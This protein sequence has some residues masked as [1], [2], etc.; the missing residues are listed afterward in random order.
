MIDKNNIKNI[1]ELTPMQE[2]MLFHSVYDGANGAY[3]E[4]ARYRISGELDRTCFEGAWNRLVERHDILRTAFVYQKVKEPIQI[5]LKQRKIECRYED[6]SDYP[7]EDRIAFCRDYIARDKKR[8]FDLS[9][10]ALMR[11]ALFRLDG[12]THEVL[13]SFHHIL[14][15]G[16]SVG[17]IQEEFIK[18]YR[19][20]LTGRGPELEQ[21]RPFVNYVRWL[22][23]M[24]AVKAH[25]YWAA[26]LEGYQKP[27]PL[28][29]VAS[30]ASLKEAQGM[31]DAAFHRHAFTFPL[32]LS[33]G[34]K[35]V[36]ASCH[37]TLNT[38]VQTLWGILLCKYHD[39]N[40]VVFAASV[41]GRPPEIKG[42]EKMV[43]LFINAVPVRITL[44][45]N[46]SLGETLSALQSLELTGKS[47]H[48]CS[49]AD[50]QSATPLKQ[51]LINHILVF[52][53]YP[54]SEV[55]KSFQAENNGLFRLTDFEHQDHT[56]YD[57]TVQVFPGMSD[58]APLSFEFIY[59][60]R[61]YSREAIEEIASNLTFL[62][63][64]MT[65]GPS[66]TLNDLSI[67]R[68]KA[69]GAEGRAPGVVISATFTAEPVA[70]YLLWWGERFGTK[71]RVSFAPYHQVFQELLD[72]E[73]T[74]RR[75]DGLRFILLRPEDWGNR[76]GTPDAAAFAD[77]VDREVD[78][79][80]D[81]AGNLGPGTVVGTFPPSPAISQNK[82]LSQRIHWAVGKIEQAVSTMAGCAYVDFS[83][84]Q[85]HYG[86]AGR[87]HD[88]VGYAQGKIP[89]TE[90]YFSAA[91]VS[92]MRTIHRMTRPPF[93]VIVLDCDNTLWKGVCGEDGAHNV[94]VTG[95]FE[96]LQRLMVDKHDQGFLI[97]LCS[98]NNEAD[99][100]EVFDNHGG[101]VL[102][103]AHVVAHRINWEP[104][105]ANI[106][107]LA[108]ELNLSLSSFIFIDDSGVEID[109]VRDALP[110]VF[111]LRLPEN[112]DH[113]EP[114]FRH[115]WAFDKTGV[116]REDKQRTRMYKAEKERNAFRETSSS[117]ASY[118]ANLDLKM[119]VYPV[120]EPLYERVAQLTKRTN[121]FNCSAIPRSASDIRGL[122]SRPD[123]FCRAVSV[124]DRYGEYGITGVVIAFVQG[125]AIVADTFL[126][127][128]RVLGRGVEHALLRVLRD[129]CVEKNIPTLSL[130][131]VETG[132]N[133]PALS[134]V[135]AVG[136]KWAV[137]DNGEGMVER[138]VAEPILGAGHITIR[139]GVYPVPEEPTDTIS[140]LP[141][142]LETDDGPTALDPLPVSFMDEKKLDA[143]IDTS[144]SLAPLYLP[145]YYA[146]AAML[147]RIRPEGD[148]RRES[149]TPFVPPQTD[150]EKILADHVKSVLSVN[151][152]GIDDD[153]FMIGGHSLKATRVVS[154]IYRQFGVEISLKDFFET[155][156]IRHLAL[157]VDQAK[158]IVHMREIAALPVRETYDISFGQ[159]R[160]WALQH[161]EE[162]FFAYNMSAAY[163]VHG[164]LDDV[165]LERALNRVVAR[166]EA[167]RTVFVQDD[168]GVKQRI[169]EAMPC[170]VTRIRF[171]DDAHAEEAVQR[172]AQSAIRDPFDL[173]VGP[174]LKVVVYTLPQRETL[175]LFIMHHIICDGWSFTLFAQDLFTAY[176]HDG[177]GAHDLDSV[178]SI[179]YKEYAAWHNRLMSGDRA[180]QMKQFWQKTLSGDLPC[181]DLKTDRP[182]PEY[183]TSNGMTISRIL[184]DHLV[185]ALDGL[186]EQF[187]VT[188]YMAITALI[189]LL[190]SRYS[191][192]R[193]II[194]GTPVAGR[195]HADFETVIG[196]FVNTLAIRIRVEP[197]DS[198]ETLIERTRNR[199]TGAFD[200][201]D[202][203]F[204]ALVQ[205]LNLAR[206]TSR[207]PLFDVMIVFQN[208]AHGHEK[209]EDIRVEPFELSSGVS[210]YDLVFMVTETRDALEFSVTFNSDLFYKERIDHMVTHVERLL[211]GV[212]ADSKA[213]VATLPML[214]DD[215]REALLTQWGTLSP[216]DVSG[217]TI[218][219]CFEARVHASPDGVALLY[220]G[221]ELT[222]RELDRGADRVLALLDQAGL[223]G[224]EAIAGVMARRG[225]AVIAAL[226]GIMKSGCVYMPVDPDMP[227]AR[228]QVIL[229]DSGCGFLFTEPGVPMVP[230]SPSFS[231][232]VIP[233][234]FDIDKEK[235][236]LIEDRPVIRSDQLAYVIYT[237]GSTGKPKGVMIAHGGFVNMIQAQ[238]RGFGI[239][240]S[241]RVV[242]FASPSFDASLSEIFMA[243]LTGAT[244]VP[245]SGEII[246]DRD[247]F[248][249]FMDREKITVATLPPSY[250]A[251]LNKAPMPCLKTVITA[252]EPAIWDDAVF[253]GGSKRYFNAYGPT[254]MSVCVS[255]YEVS[256]PTLGPIPM[257]YPIHGIQVLV[258]DEHM[259]PVPQGVVGEVYAAGAGVSKGYLNNPRL[260]RERFV[261]NPYGAM[262]PP[263]YGVLYKTG[264]RGRWLKEGGLEFCGRIDFQIKQH[265]HRIELGEIEAA[266]RT[267]S[268]IVD[269]Q[270]IVRDLSAGKKELVAFYTAEKTIPLSTLHHYLGTQ[271]PPYMMPHKFSRIDQFRL[272]LNGKIDRAYLKTIS[273]DQ[274]P[275]LPV[276]EKRPGKD[277]LLLMD[278]WKKVLN[279]ESLSVTDDFFFLG[280]DSIRAIEVVGELKKHRVPITVKDIFTHRTISGVVDC[281]GKK[282]KKLDHG[283]RKIWGELLPTPIIS[284]FL[285]DFG[286]DHHHFNH[287][288]LFRW[289]D[290]IDFTALETALQALWNHHDI[291]RLNVVKGQLF[292]PREGALPQGTLREVDFVSSPHLS[293]ELKQVAE[294][295]QAGLNLEEGPLMALVLFRCSDND[296]LLIILHHL[297]VDGVSW[298]IFLDDLSAAYESALKGQVPRLP[299]KTD[300]FIRWAEA[301]HQYGEQAISKKEMAWWEG[302]ERSTSGTLPG[303]N[304]RSSWVMAHTKTLDLSLSREDTTQVLKWG[305]ELRSVLLS[306]FS[307][308][309]SLEIP[310]KTIAITLEGHGREMH[311][312][313]VDVSRT[314]GWF[315]STFPFILDLDAARRKDV[316]E[317]GDAISK[318]IA[319]V[320][321]GGLGY[322]VWKYIT[323][324]KKGGNVDFHLK[325]EIGFNFLGHF[326]EKGHTDLFV[327]DPMDKGA[328]VSKRVPVIHDLFVNGVVLNGRL[329]LFFTYN[330]KRFKKKNMEK[331]LTDMA[332]YLTIV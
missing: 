93:K 24:D 96:F 329:T 75:H 190:L 1:Y 147:E 320:P 299:E 26:Y 32:S 252:G 118:L 247:L 218:V 112:H 74:L 326:D 68:K 111:A 201:Q 78:R 322:G 156:T 91:A 204:E 60:T 129:F 77:Q 191:G 54:V 205:D 104:K 219:E 267:H 323:A 216:I 208:N 95:G 324:K 36:A 2:G 139:F 23:G 180:A 231:W 108:A 244:V 148:R 221:R 214:G 259:N 73:S 76:D 15:D 330:S 198:F 306:A 209:W 65:H 84:I 43:G 81:L 110:E 315:T 138:S 126:L 274:H 222:Y 103:R 262:V 230:P 278:I 245:V 141:P 273:P 130:R 186:C 27:V 87:I 64:Q 127:S 235:T 242:Q 8:S 16:W 12:E 206:D 229:S 72:P 171:T 319:S 167:L 227:Q 14:I 241:D 20:L 261:P 185:S 318:M 316:R 4:Q 88:P 296:R 295:A 302:I 260:S 268:D 228:Q 263:G 101:M 150:T 284:W 116:T 56:N 163:R 158:K 248:L 187:R 194:T 154:R 98:K 298:R 28:P 135:N 18:I 131:V 279:I 21:A 31:E 294:A 149:V 61:C 37:V 166:H 317:N 182:R 233:D 238:I 114:F 134:F 234:P 292:I 102:T 161:M 45:K 66:V 62:A 136:F 196:F 80:I 170:P 176:R 197:T 232:A 272:T 67:A 202:Y 181:L 9:R 115:V 48:F 92:M 40:D 121:Q 314:M 280:G 249:S 265:G 168:H 34:L 165:R 225:P 86:L 57:L 59:H 307:K 22:K 224:T 46:N 151:S 258:L 137:L 51:D 301:L 144:P 271:L 288:E 286:V 58:D 97:A 266:M 255:I 25:H 309:L 89:Y 303:G 281:I 289:E 192:Q 117:M 124:S 304:R 203:P 210:R 313:P 311:I 321:K 236:D 169:V 41:S 195:N 53:N 44:E 5:V 305:I 264:D 164:P 223:A 276:E 212:S 35:D 226:L 312:G 332:G 293:E 207:S 188:R 239:T 105:S 215:E 99:V 85:S 297:V 270:V 153:F 160:M 175:V 172:H 285:S 246:Q 179:Q 183:K 79:F 142:P 52:E 38:L 254:E 107:S 310:E 237:S 287:S 119:T 193:D 200:N 300:S 3:F 269:A 71:M 55:V 50:I 174:L 189:H 69:D 82:V 33:Q 39:V 29:N 70:P 109:Q 213:R 10:D 243:L 106:R 277:A 47:Y 83:L 211:Q 291:L 282:E 122:A 257:G 328:S 140:V 90:T 283:A 253:Y 327:I 143:I 17:I 275:A 162:D 152:V 120:T 325:P 7:K 113:F 49:L 30:T 128:C 42:I 240:E 178:P 173:A 63:R 220:N 94:S 132:K 145:L 13:L 125:A 331:M 308:A 251:M 199:V 123:V 133:A 6:I 250:L 256:C 19:A 146:S 159:R 217:R 155:P 11:V 184:D 100:W 290:R 157:R 177:G